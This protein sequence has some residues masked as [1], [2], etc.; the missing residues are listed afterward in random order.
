M[1]R[2]A[3]VLNP[4]GSVLI[5]GTSQLLKSHG[6]LLCS[7]AADLQLGVRHPGGNPEMENT[8]KKNSLTNEIAVKLLKNS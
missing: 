7:C 5:N 3:P 8:G 4:V 2:V 6:L 1:K